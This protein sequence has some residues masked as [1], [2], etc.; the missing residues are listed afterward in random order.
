MKRI[1][2]IFPI[3]LIASCGQKSNTSQEAITVH[4]PESKPKTILKNTDT[5]ETAEKSSE[6][7]SEKSL[8]IFTEFALNYSPT[9]KPNSGVAMLPEPSDSALRAIEILKTSHPKELE[10]YLTLI[11]VKLYSAHLECCHQSYEIRR[12]PL[13]GLDRDKDPLVCEFNDLTKQFAD[14]KRVE[15]ISSS[16]AYDYVSSHIYLLDFKPI[17]KHIEVIEQVH[18]NIEDGVYWKS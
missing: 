2:Y 1:L 14:K 12:Q 13:G 15:F 6:L 11:F 10:K 16:I 3:L 17:K 8:D 9:R 18:K 5:V 7:N 4:R